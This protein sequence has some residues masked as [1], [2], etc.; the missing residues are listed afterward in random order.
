M[1]KP[2]IVAN[3][4][5]RAGIILVTA[6]VYGRI[7]LT[8]RLVFDT[9]ATH[10]ML[11]QKLITALGIPI[12]PKNVVQTTTASSV[13][14]SPLI[15]LPTIEVFGEKVDR[16]SCLIRDLPPLSGIDGLLG[17]S[18]LK[19]FNIEINFDEGSISIERF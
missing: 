3:F 12:N 6:T 16:V 15:M 17:L 8:S 13:T 9:G 11:P 18:F 19:H 14:S 2:T 4:D 10:C 1:C 7:E 5:P